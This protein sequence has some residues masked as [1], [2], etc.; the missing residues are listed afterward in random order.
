MALEIILITIILLA[1]IAIIAVLFLFKRPYKW[2][3]EVKG[4]SVVF[5]FEAQKDIKKME[6]RVKQKKGEIVFGRQNIKKGEKVE[7]NY[8]AA[9]ESAVL[10]VEDGEKKSYEI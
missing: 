1:L 3:K 6:L 8:E 5:V 2:A 4:N 7:F 10:I 9:S